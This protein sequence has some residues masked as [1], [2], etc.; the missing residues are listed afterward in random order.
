MKSYW[1]REREVV[2]EERDIGSGEGCGC[3]RLIPSES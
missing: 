1:E 3:G 2:R